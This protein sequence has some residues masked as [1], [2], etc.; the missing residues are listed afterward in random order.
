M[1]ELHFAFQSGSIS[2]G[3]FKTLTTT[4]L[5]DRRQRERALAA[6]KQLAGNPALATAGCISSVFIDGIG[7]RH[8]VA[9]LL[10]VLAP[11][12]LRSLAGRPAGC[13]A[14]SDNGQRRCCPDDV[15]IRS[16]ARQRFQTHGS[17]TRGRSDSRALPEHTAAGRHQP[18]RGR[19]TPPQPAWSALQQG[20]TSRSW[21]LL[22]RNGTAW[23]TT[24]AKVAGHRQRYRHMAPA[25]QQRLQQKMGEWAN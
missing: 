20:T 18:G 6:Q 14:L 25:E 22:A 17:K 8:A 13:R 5:R 1:N 7:V 23:R 12:L 10:L 9:A 24:G 3:G 19:A 11:R 15:P 2:I 4:G 21:H 16:A